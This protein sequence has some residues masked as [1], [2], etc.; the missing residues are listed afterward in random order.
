MWSNVPQK[1]KYHWAKY[2]YQRN[3]VVTLLSRSKQS[4]FQQLDTN[5][6]NTFWKT[7]RILNHQQSSIPALEVNSTIIDTSLDKACAL[8]NFFYIQLLQSQLS[9]PPR[10]KLMYSIYDSQTLAASDYPMELLCTEESVY[11]ELTIDSIPPNRWGVME[12]LEKC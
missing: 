5:D 2:R 1:H 8:N 11:E 4:F 10:I 12:Y 6:T 9:N 7:V 3:Y